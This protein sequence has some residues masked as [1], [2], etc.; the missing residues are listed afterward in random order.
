MIHAFRSA[1]T[2][3]LRPAIVWPAL[4]AIVVFSAMSIAFT[5][6]TA[7]APG[8]SRL[9]DPPTVLADFAASDAL[10]QIIARP[11]MVL[12][13]V[14]LAVSIL[15]VTG[16]YSS[17]LIRVLFV[18]QPRRVVWLAGNWLAVAVAA[19]MA[20]VV[21]AGVAAVTGIICARA[22]G[23]DTSAWGAGVGEALAAA[24]NL[25]LGMVAFA[26]AGSVVAVWLRS[27][28]AALAVGLVYALFEN[29]ISAASPVGRGLLP[30][31]A[32]TTVASSGL[33]GTP[34]LPSLLATALILLALLVATAGLVRTRDV[35]D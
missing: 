4:G 26:L 9:T 12:G 18:R 28:I 16:Q 7:A 20:S 33:N 2:M 22:W 15:H 32:F 31:S 11:I 19:A 10:A 24:G 29:M 23:V 27:A 35:T 6:S 5:F 13:I 21:A 1:W 8:G 14:V 25:L 3:L 34:Y 30:A 17:G